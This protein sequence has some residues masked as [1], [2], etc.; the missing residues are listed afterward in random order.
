MS[1]QPLM[2]SPAATNVRLCPNTIKT[3]LSITPRGGT[4]KPAIVIAHP[5]M[6]DA[7]IVVFLTLTVLLNFLTLLSFIV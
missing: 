4:I 7:N 2:L 6:K 3:L 1:A 5:M